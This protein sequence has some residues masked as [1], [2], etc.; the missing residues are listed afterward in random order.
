LIGIGKRKRLLPNPRSRHFE[1]AGQLVELFGFDGEREFV[2]A[3]MSPQRVGS[4]LAVAGVME[5]GAGV[6][7]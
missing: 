6:A 1:W 7:A 5:V 2:A 3:D 4:I